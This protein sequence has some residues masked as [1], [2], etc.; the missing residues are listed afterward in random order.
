MF[1]SQ[2]L[3]NKKGAFSKEGLGGVSW[4]GGRCELEGVGETTEPEGVQGQAECGVNGGPSHRDQVMQ[5]LTC[6]GAGSCQDEEQ[7]EATGS[8]Q[9]GQ[10]C[11]VSVPWPCPR[12]SFV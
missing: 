12:E 10:I 6:Q 1:L 2:E 7:G 9:L 5:G 3:K 11:M 4:R 8:S